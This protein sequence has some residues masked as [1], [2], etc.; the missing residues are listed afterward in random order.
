LF[1]EG[2]EGN[3]EAGG[4]LRWTFVAF[5][6]GSEPGARRKSCPPTRTPRPSRGVLECGGNFAGNPAPRVR[7]AGATPLWLVLENRMR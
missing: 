2:N 4:F 6:G 1:T 7:D 5:C 3:K